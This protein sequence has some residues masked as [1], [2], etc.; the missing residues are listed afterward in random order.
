MENL[1]DSGCS[2]SMC[3]LVK[4]KG[5]GTNGPCQCFH[6]IK[7]K[8]RLKILDYINYLREQVKGKNNEQ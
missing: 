5:Q 3:L 6:G 7:P 1:S 8:Q 4:P 2:S